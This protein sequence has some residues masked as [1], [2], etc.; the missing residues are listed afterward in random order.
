MNCKVFP[1]YPKISKVCLTNQIHY[2]QED[3][4]TEIPYTLETIK[5]TELKKLVLSLA[6]IENPKK[7]IERGSVHNVNQTKIK[8]ITKR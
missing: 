4:F 2:F 6:C 5:F 1:P 8:Y 3:K 7:Y